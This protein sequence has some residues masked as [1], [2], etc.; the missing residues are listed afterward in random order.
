MKVDASY[1]NALTSHRYAAGLMARLAGGRSRS[2]GQGLLRLHQ[3]T[4]VE[5]L[6]RR[7]GDGL[8]V[9]RFV[10]HR[11]PRKYPEVIAAGVAD[12]RVAVIWREGDDPVIAPDHRQER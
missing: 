12:D 10:H 9:L 2:G 4:G 5:A 6:R 3:P 7:A 11:R 8:L 1:S